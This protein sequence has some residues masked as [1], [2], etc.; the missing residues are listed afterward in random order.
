VVFNALM[1]ALSPYGIE[2]VDMPATPHR[3]WRAIQDARKTGGSKNK[4]SGEEH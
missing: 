1:D 3:V 4:T 2:H